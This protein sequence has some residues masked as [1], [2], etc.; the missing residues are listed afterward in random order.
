L[1]EDGPV[2]C[3]E[4][5]AVNDATLHYIVGGKPVLVRLQ[6]ILTQTA[7]FA[8][9]VMSSGARLP[10]LDVPLAVAARELSSAAEEL[11]ALPVPEPARHHHYHAIEAVAAMRQAI[12]LVT[13]CMRC[14]RDDPARAALTRRL[15]AATDH[16]RAASRLP[17]FGMVDL[18]H[19]CCACHADTQHAVN[20]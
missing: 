10:M 2:F 15:Q 11:R 20:S 9:L 8:L 18:R 1:G 3:Q 19:A 12:D 7:G 4:L 6:Q 14:G 13:A 5:D 17:D 16:L